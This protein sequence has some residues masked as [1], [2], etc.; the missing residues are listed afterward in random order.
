MEELSI[1]A[2]KVS[3]SRSL[4][5]VRPREIVKLEISKLTQTEWSEKQRAKLAQLSML[6][7]GRTSPLEFI[8]YKFFYHFLCDDDRCIRPHRLSV[9]DWEMSE[10]YRKWSKQYGNDWRDKFRQKYE[11]QLLNADLQFFVGTIS[12]HPMNWL[13]VGLYYPPKHAKPL[14]VPNRQ[15]SLFD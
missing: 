5:L 12:D 11:G 14:Q 15:T 9:V 7:L 6:S 2:G 8:P 13:I 4:A 10:S 1:T 3:T